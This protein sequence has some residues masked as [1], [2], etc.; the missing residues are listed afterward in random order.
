MQPAGRG[1]PEPGRSAS[2]QGDVSFDVHARLPDGPGRAVRGVSNS[3]LIKVIAR[4][5]R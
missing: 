5:R 3:V 1:Q 2:D 4:R